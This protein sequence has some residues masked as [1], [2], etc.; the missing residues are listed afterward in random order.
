MLLDRTPLF[1][2]LFAVPPS[3]VAKAQKDIAPDVGK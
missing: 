2:I 1:M 3:S